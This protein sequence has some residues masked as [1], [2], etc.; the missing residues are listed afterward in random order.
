[1]PDGFNRHHILHYNEYWRADRNNCKLR[2][3][4]GMIALMG[5]E[6]HTA[7]HNACPAPPPL[8]IHIAQRASGLYVPHTNPLI[9]ID[10]FRFAVDKALRHPRAHDIER[11]VAML[12]IE[13]VTLQLPFIREGLITDNY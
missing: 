12:T 5:V 2:Q 6:E 1:M 8:D 3:A 4:V 10:N 7:L 9:A 13:A 11:N